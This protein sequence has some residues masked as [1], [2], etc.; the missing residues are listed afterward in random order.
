M[1][2]L[3]IPDQD[4]MWDSKT[5]T[6]I[7]YKGA[8]IKLEH[9][10]ISISKWESKYHKPFLENVEMNM[11]ELIY[12]IK[13]MTITQNVRD[14]VYNYLT[15][16]NFNEIKDYISDP[17]T[18]TWF[19]EKQGPQNSKMPFSGKQIVTSELIYYWMIAQNIPLECEKWHLNRLMTLIKV[20]SIKNAEA[21]GHNTGKKM[22]QRELASYNNQLNAARRKKLNTKG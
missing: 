7:S 15:E 6:F 21:N 9:S 14:E 10:L 5:K 12:Y 22:S 1:L 17:M 19:N 4:E 20:C 2:E 16:E 18:A 3:T 11:E 8:T 13:C